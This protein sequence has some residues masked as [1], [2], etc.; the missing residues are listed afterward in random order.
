MA[1]AA[2]VTQQE[3]FFAAALRGDVERVH[4][5]LD[6]E[7]V[8]VNTGDGDLYTA[9]HRVVE[10]FIPALH[11]GM[12]KLL[13]SKGA[14]VNA[15]LPATDGWTPLHLAA[16]GGSAEAVQLLLAAGANPTL[17]D[18]YGQTAFKIAKYSGNALV[19]DV[20]AGAVGPPKT[21]L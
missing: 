16:W 4:H 2:F 5:L 20:L 14:N 19:S 12:L 1:T 11:E 15:D 8:N 10:H 21:R 6:E 3:E 18:W 9:L 17:C 7:G 13:I